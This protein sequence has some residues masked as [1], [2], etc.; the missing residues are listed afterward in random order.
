MFSFIHT[1][2]IHLDSPLRGLN[3]HADAPV[4]QIRGAT[5]RALDKLVSLALEKNVDFLLIAGDLYDG[6]WPDYSTGLFF[7]KQ[8]SR[9]NEANIPVYLISGNHDAAS[10]ITKSLKPPANV[11]VLSTKVP[12]TVLIDGLPVAIH[13]QG[14]ATQSVTENLVLEYPSASPKRFNIGM[15][16]T[17]LT[18]NP[19]HDPYAP[20]SIN[21]LTEKGYD[22]WAL[23]HIHQHAVV[24]E[25]P[26]IVYSGN[27]QGRHI[28]ETDERGCYF[29]EVADDLTIKQLSFEVTDVVRW[30]ALEIDISSLVDTD[31]LLEQITQHMETALAEANGRLLALR[32]TL[33]GDSPLHDQLHAEL[34]QWQAECVSMAAQVEDELI[35]FERLRIKTNP[36]YD[37]QELAERDDLTKLVL[38]ALNDFTPSQ[39][40][41]PVAQLR[42]KL[43]DIGNKDLQSLLALSDADDQ[44]KQDVSSIVLQ[45]ISSSAS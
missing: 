39:V 13:G 24:H 18:G 43:K 20:C 28:K 29:I 40:P 3:Q 23:G 10:K 17:S 31:A 34:S 41:A 9:L 5:R 27:P 35:W 4:D 6:D 7:N 19:E 26:H 1:A 36:T 12:E 16:H 8:M 14:F 33:V 37:P 15:L 44:L 38:E 32:I 30:K 25:S 21:D 22:Y 2:D 42:D 11:T 45:S